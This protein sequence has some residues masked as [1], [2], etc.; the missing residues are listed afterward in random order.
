MTA[1]YNRSG[2]QFMYPENWK[3]SDDDMDNIPRT[4]SVE[5]PTGAF[6]SVDI[7]PFSVDHQMLLDQTLAVF[8]QEYNE[9][10]SGPAEEIWLGE[11]VTGFDLDFVCLDFVV[12][13]QL[14]V[15]R[16]SHATYLMT[17]QA[18]DREFQELRQVFRAITQSLLSENPTSTTG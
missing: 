14:R 12:C 16:H 17:F 4:V 15:L 13:C 1:V 9:V 2:I 18:E 8:E 6:W 3:I 11:A 5:S 10:E 7:H